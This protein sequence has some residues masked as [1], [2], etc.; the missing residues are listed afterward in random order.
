MSQE[1]CG[2]WGVMTHCPS[3]R[4]SV[5]VPFFPGGL[6]QSISGWLGPAPC[7]MVFLELLGAGE[8]QGMQAASS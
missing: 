4:M 3:F 8:E 7:W 5:A 6:G 2:P 1:G